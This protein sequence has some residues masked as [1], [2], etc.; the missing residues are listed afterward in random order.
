MCITHGQKC[1]CAGI[2]SELSQPGFTPNQ[3]MFA[4]I[5]IRWH[6]TRLSKEIFI[7]VSWSYQSFIF[8]CHQPLETSFLL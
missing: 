6:D 1:Y 8:Q 5:E 7:V 2:C 4:V 3:E